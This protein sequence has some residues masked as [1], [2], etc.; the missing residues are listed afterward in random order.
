LATAID[1]VVENVAKEL[2]YRLGETLSAL[3]RATIDGASAIDSSVA[4]LLAAASTTSFSTL[5]LSGIRSQVQ[6]MAGRAIKPFNE[7]NKSFA[8]VIH[9]FVLGDVL[10]DSSN[11]SP[12]DILKHTAVGQQKMDELPSVDLEEVVELPSTGVNFFQTNL[13][14][15][16]PNY[17]PGTGAIN[18]LTA[19]RTYLMG[20]D[21]V[22]AINLGARGDTGYGDGDWRNIKCNVVQNAPISVADPSGLI[23]GWTSYKTHFTTSL[24]PDTTIRLRFI[25]GGSGIS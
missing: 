6:S 2:G 21:G 8:G 7:E 16:T 1:P 9:P 19:I 14:T 18:G 22:F 11:N 12:L 3:V 15:L 13:V 20:R 25:D 10:A 17:N 24:G 4:V 5:T 23:P